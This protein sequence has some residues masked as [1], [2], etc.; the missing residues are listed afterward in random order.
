MEIEDR[1]KDNLEVLKGVAATSMRA[2]QR[3]VEDGKKGIA[4]GMAV[5]LMG[6]DASGEPDV[7]TVI[8]AGTMSNMDELME[9]ASK[10]A[11]ELGAHATILICD[12]EV[13]MVVTCKARALGMTPETFQEDF[14]KLS[15]EHKG[16]VIENFDAVQAILISVFGNF[17][18]HSRY[19]Q[20]EEGY[21]WTDTLTTDTP[22]VVIA[23][24]PAAELSMEIIPSEMC[25]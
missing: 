14:L 19:I 23:R 21:K 3:L 13:G 25:S 20:D 15:D 7:A 17:D 6:N 4:L 16:E 22:G 24:D 2:V 12:M 8:H 11:S 18:M 5:K 9:E 10:S 1:A